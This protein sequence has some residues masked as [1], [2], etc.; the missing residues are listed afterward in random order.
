MNKTFRIA[1]WGILLAFHPEGRAANNTIDDLF[2]VKRL[3]AKEAELEGSPKGLKAG[4]PLYFAR[5]PFKFTVTAVSGKKVTIALPEKHDL[6]VGNT[7]M[8]HL[9]DTVIKSLDTE[10]RIKQALEE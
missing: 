9:T 3:E 10:I 5:S 2:T 7:L 8:R 4:D 6:S 1:L